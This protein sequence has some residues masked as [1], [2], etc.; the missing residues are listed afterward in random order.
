MTNEQLAMY[1]ALGLTV[2]VALVHMQFSHMRK[3]MDAWRDAILNALDEQFQAQ[4]KDIKA[5]LVPAVSKSYIGSIGAP[6]KAKDALGMNQIKQ[7]NPLYDNLNNV[8]KLKSLL[9]SAPDKPASTIETK[10]EAPP[11]KKKKVAPK[12]GKK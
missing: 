6:A 5:A 11:K 4:I 1:G 2:F 12:K 3:Q 8:D 10:I 9:P 7:Q